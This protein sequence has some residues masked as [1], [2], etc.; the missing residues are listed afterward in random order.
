MNKAG[1]LE[2]PVNLRRDTEISKTPKALGLALQKEQKGRRDGRKKDETVP[3]RWGKSANSLL[4]GQN[5]G[6]NVVT[7]AKCAVLNDFVGE[8]VATID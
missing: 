6:G 7:L 2:K 5:I 8:S 1:Y 3:R 4:Q